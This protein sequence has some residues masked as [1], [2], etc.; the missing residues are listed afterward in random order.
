MPKSE[1]PKPPHTHLPKSEPTNPMVKP[2]S[3]DF[4]TYNYYR[5]QKD[6]QPLTS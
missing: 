4:R 1:P 2:N 6:T 5:S 3:P